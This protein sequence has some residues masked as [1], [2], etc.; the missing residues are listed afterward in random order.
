V[1]IDPLA[2]ALHVADSTHLVPRLEDPKYIPALRKIVRREA[3]DMIFPL[4]DPDIPVLAGNMKTFAD[5][6]AVLMTPPREGVDIATDKWLTCKTYMNLGIPTARTW[7]PEEYDTE[8]PTFPLFIKPRHGSA[9]KGAVR[10]EDKRQMDFFL[11]YVKDPI[12]Q[13]YLPGPEITCDVAC[14]REGDIW[15]VVC[16]KRIEVRAGE[17]AKGVTLWDERIS[18]W[19][20]SLAQ[21]IR[22]RGPITVQCL[23]RG[24]EPVFT[25]INA[26]FGGGCPLGIAAGAD[27]PRWYLAEAAGMDPQ[28]PPMGTYRKGLAMTRYDESFFLEKTDI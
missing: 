24:G 9:G 1:D 19:C 18:R 15:A 22:A 5:E 28:V 8:S 17:V 2:P 10:I 16:R 13:E 7:L 4:I 6:G 23:M 26:R 27:Y 20:I 14:S 3:V 11:G 12:L 21:G 25:E